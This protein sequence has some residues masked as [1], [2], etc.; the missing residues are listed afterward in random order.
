MADI[1][2][3]TG[4][5]RQYHA[6][7]QRLTEIAL[8]KAG[9]V[10]LDGRLEHATLA[11]GLLTQVECHG[12][13]LAT[14]GFSSD[15]LAL[16]IVLPGRAVHYVFTAPAD[17]CVFTLP[18]TDFVAHKNPAPATKNGG[19]VIGMPAVPATNHAAHR[20]HTGASA[21][22]SPFVSLVSATGTSSVPF[23]RP[24]PRRPS[25]NPDVL[26]D[27]P[28]ANGRVEHLQVRAAAIV[29]ELQKHQLVV[30]PLSI[31]LAFSL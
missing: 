30:A 14:L 17:C 16:N 20:D 11:L 7:M 25:R 5:H 23:H 6:S 21:R 12:S 27:V 8:E 2:L 19:R 3:V 31:V 18:P 22:S 24:G 10:I 1:S 28:H 9:Q 26:P 15:C 29:R 13:S 4:I